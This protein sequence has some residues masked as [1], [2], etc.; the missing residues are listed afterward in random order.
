MPL[1]VDICAET[2]YYQQQDIT[3]VKIYDLTFKMIF[4]HQESYFVNYN[5]DI[6]LLIFKMSLESP[7]ES[8]QMYSLFKITHK[9]S[10]TLAAICIY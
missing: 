3:L 4:N 8:P 2:N 6:Y 10:I 9:F 5:L 1:I 7:N